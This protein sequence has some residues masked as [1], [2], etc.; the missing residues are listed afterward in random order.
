LKSKQDRT[1]RWLETRKVHD[2]AISKLEREIWQLQN[3]LRDLHTIRIDRL[4]SLRIKNKENALEQKDTDLWEQKMILEEKE[5][6]VHNANRR[7]GKAIRMLQI[8]IR[9]RQE[10]EQWEKKWAEE[11]NHRKTPKW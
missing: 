8:Y 9:L 4:E 1:S 3:E 6:E 5:K 7:D 2:D 10:D 11:R